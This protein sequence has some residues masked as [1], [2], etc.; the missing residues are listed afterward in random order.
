MKAR[1]ARIALVVALAVGL[2]LV[3]NKAHAQAYKYKDEAGHV[4]FTE[5]YYEVPEKYRKKLETREM[6]VVVDKNAP[7]AEPA[8]ANEV[9]FQDGVRTVSGKDLTVQQQDALAKWWKSWGTTWMIVGGITLALQLAIHLGLIVHALT[10]NH[11]G[12]GLANFLIGVT[13]PIYL[14]VHVEQSMVTRLGLLA[15]Y[16]APGIVLGIAFNQIIAVLS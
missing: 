3:A 13:T 9:A 11:V 5:N 12:W 10:N 4:H 1:V 16:F 6:P 14:M 15:M 8:G 7:N 2:G